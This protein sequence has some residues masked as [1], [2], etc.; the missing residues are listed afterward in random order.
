[1]PQM[2]TADLRLTAF[3]S[4][5]KAIRQDLGRGLS[6]GV[7]R[8]HFVREDGL[9]TPNADDKNASPATFTQ[10]A[11]QGNVASNAH[12]LSIKRALVE[13]KLGKGGTSDW[14]RENEHMLGHLG[15]LVF[16]AA[17]LKRSIG[18]LQ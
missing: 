12:K 18:P 4:L 16:Y 5:T 11:V 3:S 10:L 9:L 1:M 13:R 6:T 14:H 17:E 8:G 7:Q 2:A 15:V